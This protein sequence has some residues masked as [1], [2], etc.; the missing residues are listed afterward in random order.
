MNGRIF[1]LSPA[2]ATGKRAAQL[3][4]PG[5]TFDLAVRLRK[6]GVSLGEA[7]AFL[8]GLY[9]RG[10][11]AYATAFARESDEVYVLTA[12]R[13]LLPPETVISADELRAFAT[14][15]IDIADDR[16]VSALSADAG[17]LA[18]REPTTVILLGSIASG[19][20]VDVLLPLFG[21]RLVFPSEF[22]GRGDMSRGGLMLRSI[23]E[24]R[25]LSY[26]PIA[27]AT[28]RGSRPPRLEP[29]RR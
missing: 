17:Q 14:S 16:Y 8:S 3:L 15:N 28:R 5:A 26:L 27:G 23:A 9:F 10:K 20:Y 25:E 21:E 18:M 13:G 12:N 6:V 2:S 1:L 24:G 19:K 11:L 22:V 7:F 4:N 29:I